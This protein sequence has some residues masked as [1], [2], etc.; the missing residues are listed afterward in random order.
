MKK[1][2]RGGK[3]AAVK[4]KQFGEQNAK[5]VRA[6]TG[7]FTRT[8]QKSHPLNQKVIMRGGIRL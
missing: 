5:P 3:S 2:N 7:D 8:A 6:G 1:M 4:G